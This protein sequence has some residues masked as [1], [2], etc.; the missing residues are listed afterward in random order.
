MAPALPPLSPA[1]VLAPVLPPQAGCSPA[2]PTMA[3]WGHCSKS[4]HPQALTL[5]CSPHPTPPAEQARSM[6]RRWAGPRGHCCLLSFGGR[7]PLPRAGNPA[8]GSPT[9]ASTPGHLGRPASPTCLHPGRA[10]AQ[11]VLASHCPSVAP[12]P[13]QAPR[14]PAPAPLPTAQPGEANPGA[15]R[16]GAFPALRN[17]TGPRPRGNTE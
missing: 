16:L 4:P 10:P 17:R 9:A 2:F 12:P 3:G 11:P 7:E 6:P 1:S 15:V 14:P 13:S 5:Y 8:W